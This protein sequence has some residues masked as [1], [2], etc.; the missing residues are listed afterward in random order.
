M[1]KE[2]AP[3]MLD[4]EVRKMPTDAEFRDLLWTYGFGFIASAII[5][6]EVAYFLSKKWNLVLIE[7][8]SLSEKDNA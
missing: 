5:G 4:A 7:P 8:Q 3:V 6:K 1:N 2:H